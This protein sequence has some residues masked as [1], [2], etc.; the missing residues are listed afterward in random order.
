MKKNI[1]INSN[2]YLPYHN[3]LFGDKTEF[4]KEG[5][6]SKIDY[7][8]KKSMKIDESLRVLRTY[9]IPDYDGNPN[10]TLA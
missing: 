6:N 7:A 8:T 9:T 2:I 5:G 1:N 3:F 4:Q 10:F